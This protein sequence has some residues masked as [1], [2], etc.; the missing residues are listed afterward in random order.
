MHASWPRPPHGMGTQLRS[1][2]VR[3]RG[4]G[5]VRGRGR[6]RVGVW[7]RVRVRA[8]G[9]VS[10]KLRSHQR[11]LLYCVPLSASPRLPAATHVLVR[12]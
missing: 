10:P 1:H 2:L 9:R 4:R 5:G 8:R 11:L 3:G 7:F 6:G 12:G